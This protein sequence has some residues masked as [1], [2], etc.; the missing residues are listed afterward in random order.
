MQDDTGTRRPLSH[1]TVAR[2]LLEASGDPRLR[3]LFGLPPKREPP[4]AVYGTTYEALLELPRR[5]KDSTSSVVPFPIIPRV[6]AYRGGA[7]TPR[8]RRPAPKRPPK[9]R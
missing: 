4:P 6:Q 5:R 7:E 3:I 8:R 2:P 1:A 9:K